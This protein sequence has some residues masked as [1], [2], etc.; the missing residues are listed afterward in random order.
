M[1]AKAFKIACLTCAAALIPL[2]GARIAWAEP[3]ATALPTGFSSSGAS[4]GAPAIDNHMTINQHA[5]RAV[6]DWQNFDIGR[7]ARVEFKQPT[8]SSIAVN[9]VNNGN[10]PTQIFGQLKANGRI[11]IL[12]TNGVFFGNTAKV[13]VGGLIASTGKLENASAFLDSGLLTLGETNAA[14]ADASVTNAGQITA[15]EGGLIALVA[16]AVR[17]SGIIQAHLGNVTLASGRAAT[18]DFNGDGLIHIAITEALDKTFSGSRI[19]NSGAITADGGRVYMTA[20]AGANLVS[21]AI[22]NTGIISAQHVSQRDGK[23][24]LDRNGQTAEMQNAVYAGTGAEIQAVIDKLAAHGTRDLYLASGIYH[25]SLTLPAGLRL[26]G[27][28]FD[29]AKIA[30]N[31]STAPALHI[32]GNDVT[33]EGLT[34]QNANGTGLYA[35]AVQ[36]LQILRNVFVQSGQTAIAL[37]SSAADI[38]NSTFI[39]SGDAGPITL[40][41]S[42]PVSIRENVFS[43]QGYFAVKSNSAQGVFVTATQALAGYTHELL[44]TSGGSTINDSRLRTSTAPP[45]APQKDAEIIIIASEAGAGMNA[46]Q[47]AAIAPAA[48]GDSA[49]S[50]PAEDSACR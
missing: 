9:R 49:A 14:Q 17:N 26:R 36:G 11:V 19:S 43:G 23:I 50:C 32:T 47:L 44:V 31:G 48:G 29:D 20:R 10:D 2:F 46:A 5:A 38:V 12:D 30:G 35:Y 21:S 15:A 16:P 27:G 45:A 34:V 3:A 42:R 39:Y 1:P 28:Q 40:Q 22:N 8:A 6:I 25:Q 37:V 33:V 24:I 4:I 13:D 18:V 41:D 7:D